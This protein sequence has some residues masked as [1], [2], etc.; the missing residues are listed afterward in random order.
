MATR[1]QKVMWLAF[2]ACI[3]FLSDSASLEHKP[4]QGCLTHTLWYIRTEAQ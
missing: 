2:S 3:I 4:E 1:K